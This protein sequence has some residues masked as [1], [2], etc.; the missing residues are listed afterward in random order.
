VT[1]T[2]D[3]ALPATAHTDTDTDVE[4]DCTTRFVEDSLVV[5]AGDCPGRGDLAR[6]PRCRATAIDALTDRDATQVVVRTCGLERA[7]DD[8]AVALLVAAGRFVETVTFHDRTLAD[9]ARRDPLRAA[10]DAAARAPPVS[11]VAAESGLLIATEGVRSPGDADRYATTLRAFEG[12][13]IARSRVGAR[14][15]PGAR[16]VD[17]RELDTGAVVRVYDRPDGRWYHLDPPGRR[18]SATALSTLV[19]AHERLAGS[20]TTDGQTPWTAPGSESGSGTD[21]TDVDAKG[22]DLDRAPGRAV[23][24]VADEGAP[25]ETLARVLTKHT[26]GYGVLEDCFAD[27]RVSD[28]YVTAP[29]EKTPVRVVLDGTAVET[30]VRLTRAGAKTL[31]SRLRRE[32]GR[33]FSRASP[34]LAATTETGCGRVRVAGVAD[35]VSEGVA[36][37]FRDHGRESF[38][39]P[40]LVANGTVPSS[41]AAFLSVAVERDAAGLV[42]GTRGAGKTTLLAALL[43]E[44]PSTT[45]TVLVEDTPELPADRLRATGRDVQTLRTRVG[46]GEGEADGPG[47]TATEAV[48]TALRL[49]DGALVL[50]E[51]RGEEAQALYEAMRVGASANAVLGTVHGDGAAAARERVVSD[52]GVPESSFAVTDLVVT[53]ARVQSDGPGTDR[54]VVAVE[55]VLDSSDGDGVDFAPL[56]RFDGEAGL[57]PTGR[58]RRGNS[59]LLET[60]STP[61][62]SYGELLERVDDRDRFLSAFVE[63]GRT[64]PESVAETYARRR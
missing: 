41:A 44:L 59:G 12:P 37:A 48:R 56:F 27:P 9:R 19:A 45:R 28:V 7:Y 8:T 11:D 16:L 58:L 31:A 17:A 57:V 21:P 15:P 40:R 34:T 50:G 43:W 26:R 39:L 4:C 53:V 46:V 49:G 3:H 42:V 33:A 23:R 1:Y 25:V 36:F 61:D 62:E 55:E 22:P 52:L 38:T 54:R 24:A 35:P 51:V 2:P 47:V 20:A 18:L 60:L 64:D 10:A 29:V 5:D 32:S 63:K 30:N 6:R 14:P 13:T